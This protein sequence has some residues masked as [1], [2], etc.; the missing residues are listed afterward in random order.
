[1]RACY[2]C[3]VLGARE[4]SKKQGL[5]LSFLKIKGGIPEKYIAPM[6]SF[7]KLHFIVFFGALGKKKLISKRKLS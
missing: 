3:T 1:M 7:K 5:N 6:H 4:E 2:I